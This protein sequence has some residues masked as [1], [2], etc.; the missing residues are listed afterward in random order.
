MDGLK[1]MLVVISVID[2]RSDGSMI[3]LGESAL[4][5]HQVDLSSKYHLL[6]LVCI[7]QSSLC[8]HKLEKF[9]VE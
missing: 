8:L 1:L 3:F 6:K 7:L 2:V 4:S 5:I 9:R